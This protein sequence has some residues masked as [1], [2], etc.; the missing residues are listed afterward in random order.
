[1]AKTAWNSLWRPNF[2]CDECHFD[3]RSE[4]V[5]DA[6]SYAVVVRSGAQA[7]ISDA[8]T[9]TISTPA[10]TTQPQSQ[11]ALLGS[12]VTFNAGA[13]G[14]GPLHFQWRFNGANIAGAVATSYTV[15]D[16]QFSNAGNYSVVVTDDV[17]NAVS[18]NAV[19]TVHA[20]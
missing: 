5:T 4:Q 16:V 19:L 9:L 17:S 7:I 2:R 3:D 6:G 1:M 18:S 10:F 15:T 14:S 12:S 11:T 20:A 13:A 8:A